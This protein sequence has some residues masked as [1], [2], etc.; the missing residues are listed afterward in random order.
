M[1]RAKQ[2]VDHIAN[3]LKNETEEFS[4]NKVAEIRNALLSLT[5]LQIQYR[6]QVHN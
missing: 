1:E 2:Q 3:S 4:K 5:D 6:K